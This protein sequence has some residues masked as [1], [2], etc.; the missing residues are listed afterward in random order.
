[1]T[2]SPTISQTR[3]DSAHSSR[4]GSAAKTSRR[5]ARRARERAE[6]EKQDSEAGPSGTT[7]DDA[8]V[9]VKPSA[10]AVAPHDATAPSFPDEEDFIAFVFSD[11]EKDEE[12]EVEEE[13]PPVREWDKG[14]GKAKDYEGSARKRKYDE[15]DLN[16]GYANKKQRTNAASRLAPWAVDVDWGRCNNVAEMCVR[17]ADCS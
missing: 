9:E 13:A 12:G 10:T 5:A 7:H 15:V 3:A 1:M 2:K 14:K 11:G 4:S 6:K 16:D 17:T 8:S